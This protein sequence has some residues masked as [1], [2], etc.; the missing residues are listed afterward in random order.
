M[1][2]K[3]VHWSC[4]YCG[5]DAVA[6]S[7]NSSDLEVDWDDHSKDGHL[8]LAIRVVVCP[9][10]DCGEYEIR[11]SL[12]KAE[13]SPSRNWRRTGDP[14]MEWQLRP[15]SSARAYPAYVPAPILQDYEEA[16]AICDLSPKASA[17]LSRRCLQGMIRDFWG[18]TKPR[19]IDEI[20]A[21]KTKTDP[22]TWQAIDAVRSVGNIGAHMER[23]I[24][25]VVDVDPEEA[26]LLI[27]LLEVLLGDWYI[28]RH[29]REEQLKRI[30]ALGKTKAAARKNQP[31]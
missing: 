30:V 29:E 4:P 10:K 3:A 11:A 31:S 1:D 24:N 12:Y 20:D 28:V 14:L 27:G 16:C 15:G 19:L 13:L 7:E 5:R 18:V 9:S 21:I 26:A 17:T 2:Y 8:L 22:L 25:L 23:D 6:T